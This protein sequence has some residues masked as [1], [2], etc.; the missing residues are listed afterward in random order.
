MKSANTFCINVLSVSNAKLFR[1][2]PLIKFSLEKPLSHIIV[3]E[4]IT[5]TRY[6][7]LCKPG[8]LVNRSRGMVAVPFTASLVLLMT[9]S[10]HEFV[11]H[12]K[13]FV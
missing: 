2:W 10:H 6:Q 11:A 9:T 8:Q 3:L 13:A 4:E 5:G 7:S 1:R 12:S